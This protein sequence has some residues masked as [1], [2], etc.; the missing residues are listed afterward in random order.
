[1]KNILY[2]IVSSALLGCSAAGVLATNDPYEKLNN[3]YTMLNQGRLIPAEKLGKEALQQFKVSNDIF[4]QG[5]A[6]TA[7]GAVYKSSNKPIKSISHFEKAISS[8][9]SLNDFANTSKAKFGLANA[10]AINNQPVE[11]CK[12]YNESL[13]DYKKGLETNPNMKFQFNPNYSSFE[14]MVNSFIGEYCK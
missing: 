3:S 4:G 11:Q 13:L 2:L 1:M 9:T 6:H 5:E 14:A 12:L 8:F 10:Y 7:L